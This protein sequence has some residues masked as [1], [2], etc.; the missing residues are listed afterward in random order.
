VTKRLSFL[1]LPLLCS[2][3]CE[4]FCK[5]EI[6]AARME[7]GSSEVI[8]KSLS[9]MSF[10]YSTLVV[11]AVIGIALSL[12]TKFQ[13]GWKL[14]IAAVSGIALLLSITFCSH[15]L[16]KYDWIIGLAIIAAGATYIFWEMKNGFWRK[17][18]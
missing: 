1:F 7:I 18:K 5:D 8:T 9:G 4:V 11:A 12:T 16:I 13:A 3:C 10:L 17:D 6:D 14:S 2:G 15:L